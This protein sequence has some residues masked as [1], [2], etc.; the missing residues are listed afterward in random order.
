MKTWN[1]RKSK[2]NEIEEQTIKLSLSRAFDVSLTEIAKYLLDQASQ[3][4]PRMGY[5][6]MKMK[7]NAICNY[8]EENTKW[9]EN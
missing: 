8:D 3:W 7:L 5:C 9:Y 1:D 2:D 4:H 6:G